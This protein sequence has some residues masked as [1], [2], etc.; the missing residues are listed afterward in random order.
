MTDAFL[1]LVPH[2]GS[3]VIFAATFLSCLALPAPSSV[4]MLAGGAFVASGDLALLPVAGSALSGALL[5]D[6]LGF[7]L[8]RTGGGAVL[9]WL[10]RAP[11]RARAIAAARARLDRR[12]G[13]TVFLT[14]WLFSPLG[15][16][17]NFACGAAHL[18]WPRFALPGAAGE[19]VWVTLYIGLGY[20]FAA[21]IVEL[22]AVLGNLA[23][24]LAAG[25]V[26]LLL[27]RRVF[28]HRAAT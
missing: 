9:A 25:A 18:A 1:E 20:A 26:A 14:R 22:G 6:N 19:L 11:A 28:G 23:G 16:Y 12:A 15:P 17:V 13:M 4:I 5:G 7:L 10:S 24:L 27:I 2:Y 3:W 8:G 21:S